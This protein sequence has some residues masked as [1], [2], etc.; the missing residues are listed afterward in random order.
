MGRQARFVVSHGL[1]TIKGFKET[2]C[3]KRFF[4]ELHVHTAINLDD[5]AANVA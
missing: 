2:A 3:V 5:L 4:C 1:K